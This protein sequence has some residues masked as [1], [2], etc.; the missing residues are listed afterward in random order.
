MNALF[1]NV[2]FLDHFKLSNGKIGVYWK[3]EHLFGNFDRHVLICEDGHCVR[4][5]DDGKN[6]NREGTKE[7]LPNYECGDVIEKIIKN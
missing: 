7:I 4:C 6:L 5:Y 1:E 3:T 2:K